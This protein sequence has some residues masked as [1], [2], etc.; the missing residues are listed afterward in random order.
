MTLLQIPEQSH[1]GKEARFELLS[2]GSYMDLEC[3]GGEK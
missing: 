1:L 3:W 2:P